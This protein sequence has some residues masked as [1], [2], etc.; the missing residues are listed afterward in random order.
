MSIQA[1]NTSFL[2]IV[3]TKKESSYYLL[4]QQNFV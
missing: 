3:E 2:K 1:A 4:Q